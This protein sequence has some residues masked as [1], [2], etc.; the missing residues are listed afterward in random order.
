MRFLLLWVVFLFSLNAGVFSDDER[1]RLAEE[2]LLNQMFSSKV[3]KQTRPFQQDTLRDVCRQRGLWKELLLSE[4]TPQPQKRFLLLPEAVGGQYNLQNL[5]RTLHRSE[6]DLEYL[7]PH[8]IENN[9]SQ[10][11]QK[12]PYILKRH[13]L[14]SK[15][16]RPYIL[17]R[18][19]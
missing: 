18:S 8:Q 17:K 4:E 2:D 9:E 13:L 3:S 15:S 14:S 1:Q 5:C 6:V 16:R 7:N 10:L 19:I 11:K 12:S